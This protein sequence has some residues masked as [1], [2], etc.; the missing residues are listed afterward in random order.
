V[1]PEDERPDEDFIRELRED[2]LA[3][4]RRQLRRHSCASTQEALIQFFAA[5]SRGKSWDDALAELDKA[6][7]PADAQAKG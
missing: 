3:H 1:I 4:F 5:R 2:V 6:P 7:A